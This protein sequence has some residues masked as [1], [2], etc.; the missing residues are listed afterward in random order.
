MFQNEDWIRQYRDELGTRE[1]VS[2]V[3][4][5]HENTKEIRAGLKTIIERYGIKSIVDVPC[6]DWNWM[7]LVDLHG[8]RYT[9]YDIVPDMVRDNQSKYGLTFK[10]LDITTSIPV[11][12]DLVICRDLLFHLPEVEVKA[13]LTNI[14]AS[15]CEYLLTTTFPDAVN[16]DVPT[17]GIQWRK[18]NLCAAPYRMKQPI[19]KI[20]ENS[21]SACQGRIVGLFKGASCPMSL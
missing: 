17:S 1:S 11:L 16:S 18:I 19:F 7:K 4:S 14:W 21:S 8:I 20:Q 10:V 6:G 5:T 12:A 15:G 13:A 2:G 9:G 3:G